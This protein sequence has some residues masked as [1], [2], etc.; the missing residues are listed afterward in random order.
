A[1]YGLPSLLAVGKV[2]IK[3]CE[4]DF[5]VPPAISRKYLKM[6]LGSIIMEGYLRKLGLQATRHGQC[7]MSG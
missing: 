1:P 7:L 3:A 5:A 2:M 6:E 4:A